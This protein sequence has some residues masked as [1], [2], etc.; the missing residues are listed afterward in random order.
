MAVPMALARLRAPRREILCASGRTRLEL[1]RVA[2]SLAGACMRSLLPLV[3]ARQRDRREIVMTNSYWT[4]APCASRDGRAGGKDRLGV[5]DS[6][7][8]PVCRRQDLR[9]SKRAGMDDLAGDGR[10][11][12]SDRA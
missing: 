7:S 2:R 11:L 5:W 6:S 10:S 4:G 8:R 12:G 9:A 3:R 1:E